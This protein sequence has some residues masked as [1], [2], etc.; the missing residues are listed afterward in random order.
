MTDA[1]WGAI[2]TI[3]GLV[4]NALLTWSARREARASKEAAMEVSS[5]TDAQT[6]HIVEGTKAAVQAEKNTNGSLTDMQ[7]RLD[8]LMDKYTTLFE[9]MLARRRKDDKK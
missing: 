2:T 9:Q 3:V 8:A 6:V 4:I 1:G 7:K 5:K